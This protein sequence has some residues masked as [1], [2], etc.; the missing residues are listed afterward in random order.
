MQRLSSAITMAL[1]GTLAL[2]GALALA[3]CGA[4]EVA[5]NVD[6]LSFIDPQEQTGPYVAPPGVVTPPDPIEP[7]AIS[8]IEGLANSVVMERV[9]LSFTLDFTGDPGTG[10]GTAEVRF[11]FAD[12]DSGLTIYQTA[13]VYTGVVA[14]R[15]GTTTQLASTFAAT[16]ENGLLARFQSGEFVFGMAMVYDASG[17]LQPLGGTWVIRRIDA[18]VVGTGDVF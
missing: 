12:S 16:Q 3:G 7:Q 5:V 10:D 4:N 15:G 6:L 9:D 11:Y 17:S 2:A 18:M 8:L 1:A 13:P 14:L